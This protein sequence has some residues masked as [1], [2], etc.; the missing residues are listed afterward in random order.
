MNEQLEKL[1]TKNITNPEDTYYTPKVILETIE[2]YFDIEFEYDAASNNEVAEYLGIPHYDTK[3][4]DGLAED[5][6]HYKNIWINPPF[7]I[8]KEFIKKAA[9]YVGKPLEPH[10][11]FILVPDKSL[12]NK[13]MYD[14]LGEIDYDLIIPSGRINFLQ[15]GLEKT[16]G[17]F[18]G[19]VILRISPVAR[20]RIYKLD[21]KK[22]KIY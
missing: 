16:K 21:L 17:A 18:F 20:G 11:I 9:S 13:Y 4:T 12:T 15:R 2:D 8:K 1:N 22:G 7:S 10:N 5:W 19:S 6:T 14:L 3:E